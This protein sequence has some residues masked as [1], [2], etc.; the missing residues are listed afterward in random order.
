MA[1]KPHHFTTANPL[2][3][4]MLQVVLDMVQ[5]PYAPQLHV[6]RVHNNG[7]FLTRMPG[8]KEGRAKRSYER[9]TTTAFRYTTFVLSIQPSL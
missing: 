6:E 9:C 7:R 2:D 8:A 1:T 3:N 4:V 5:T